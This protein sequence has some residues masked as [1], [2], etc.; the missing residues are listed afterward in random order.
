[1][2]TRDR[3]LRQRLKQLANEL[4]EGTASPLVLALV[5]GH[6]FSPKEIEEFRRL[7]DQLEAKNR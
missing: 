1:V 7:L 6:R 4:C 2:V 3:L 5:E